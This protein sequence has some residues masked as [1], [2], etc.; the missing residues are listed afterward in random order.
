MREKWEALVSKTDSGG[1]MQSFFW[2]EFKQRTGW[3]TFKIGIEEAGKLIGGAVIM[4][5][6]F[7]PTI[8]FL[9]LPEGPIFNFE[10][11]RAEKIFHT[12]M[13]EIDVIADLSGTQRT[14]HIRIEPRASQHLDFLKKF[15]KAPYNLE[16]RDTML[17]DLTKSK[18]TI[19]ASMKPKGRYNIHIAEREGIT[20][21]CEDPSTE[22]VDD[23][24]QIYKETT[25]RN[26]IESKDKRYFQTLFDHLKDGSHAKLFFAHSKK[27]ILATALVIFFGDRATYFFGAS[28][29][30]Q[31]NKMAP[32][33]LHW[34]IIQYAKKMGYRFYDFW[35]VSPQDANDSHGW[36]GITKFKQ[37]FGGSRKTFIGAYDFIYNEA[38]YSEFLKESG[39]I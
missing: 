23:F 7:S 11:P 22:H 34:E 15:R 29:N 27:N 2:A 12:L 13:S 37:K 4:K 3:D 1:F 21:S 36:L 9:Y 30:A 39:E 8:N 33:K 20:V 16:P 38:L 31:R 19:S 18:E 26:K 25:S 5:F 32:Y 17:V 28:S 24:F 35:G 10:S 6:S 14:S